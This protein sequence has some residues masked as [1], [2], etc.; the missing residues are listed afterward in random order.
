MLIFNLQ[1]GSSPVFMAAG[2][3]HIEALRLLLTANGDP[4]QADKVLI[5]ATHSHPRLLKVKFHLPFL[6][7]FYRQ[8]GATPFFIAA[9]NGHLEVLELLQDWGVAN[10]ISNFPISSYYEFLFI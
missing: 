7:C 5:E 2:N 3:G 9:Q 8:D 4:N 10:H 1:N 6:S